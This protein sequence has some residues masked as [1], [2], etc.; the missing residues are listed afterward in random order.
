MVPFKGMEIEKCSWPVSRNG[1]MKKVVKG[2]LQYHRVRAILH[3]KSRANQ[4]G[5]FC[6][7]FYSTR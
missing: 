7:K 1:H 3:F 4:I 5:S 6:F 2:A